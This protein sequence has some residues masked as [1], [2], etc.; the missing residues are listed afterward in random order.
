MKKIQPKVGIIGGG[1]AGVYT[2][3]LLAQ[4]NVTFEIIEAKPILG[5][6]IC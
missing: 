5:G 1:L 2:A 4:Q 6:R 3:Y